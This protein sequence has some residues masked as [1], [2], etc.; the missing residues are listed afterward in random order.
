MASNKSLKLASQDLEHKIETVKSQL[1]DAISHETL[2]AH[3]KKL[4]NVTTKLISVKEDTL[5]PSSVTHQEED[6]NKRVT[7]ASI[8]LTPD[9]GVAANG[10]S[11]NDGSTVSISPALRVRS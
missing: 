7:H 5:S 10:S 2:Q 6:P 9:K 3:S 4:N 11:S 1:P 8:N